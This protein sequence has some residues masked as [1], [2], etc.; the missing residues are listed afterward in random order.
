MKYYKNKKSL[1]GLRNPISINLRIRKIIGI[2]G[3]DVMVSECG[4]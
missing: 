4:V 3:N 2:Y 1:F